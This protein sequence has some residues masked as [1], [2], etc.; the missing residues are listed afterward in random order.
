MP[1]LSVAEEHQ[2]WAVACIEALSRQV[3]HL[4]DAPAVLTGI[5]RV[6]IIRV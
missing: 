1:S 6:G 5:D 4:S 3:Q 2:A